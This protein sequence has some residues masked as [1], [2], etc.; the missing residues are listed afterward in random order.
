MK[1]RWLVIFLATSILPLSG[2][3]GTTKPVALN[4]PHGTGAYTLSEPLPDGQF[5]DSRP[6]EGALQAAWD[7]PGDGSLR[8]LAADADA[9]AVVN[10]AAI[11][12]VDAPPQAIPPGWPPE[13]AN[14]GLAYVTYTAAV[15]Q[16]VKGTAAGQILVTD[17]AVHEGQVLYPLASGTFLLQPGRKYFLL[18]A[19]KPPDTPGQGQYLL[20]GS[21]RAGFEVTDGFV[22]VL[23]DPIAQDLQQQFGGLPLQQFVDIIK[24]YVAAPP[25][26]PPPGP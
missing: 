5:V 13:A 11:V 19:T 17:V 18:L 9:A 1:L 20:M 7:F 24:G 23:N 8:A 16:W 3:G 25:A 12:N 21:G 26:P 6:I 4:Q 14:S 15:E 22:H 10:I 2:C